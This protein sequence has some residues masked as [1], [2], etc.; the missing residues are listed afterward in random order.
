MAGLIMLGS[1][2]A[3]PGLANAA[4]RALATAPTRGA[5]HQSGGQRPASDRAV[6]DRLAAM[7]TERTDMLATTA[8]GGPIA[9]GAVPVRAVL[10]PPAAAGAP[11]AARIQALGAGRQIYLVLRGLRAQEQPGIVYNLYL[12]L[13]SGAAPRENDPRYVGTLNFFNA[14]PL[15]GAEPPSG[16][17]APQEYSF[18]VTELVEALQARKALSDPLTVTIVPA[19]TPASTTKP[20][21]QEIRLV[22][23]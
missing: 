6:F 9:L 12:A 4:S 3:L 2:A 19:G 15:P 21:I 17:G 1:H 10:Q 13:P 23:Q 16:E 22:A 8:S 14:V 20:L 18:D 11:L 7:D 5:D